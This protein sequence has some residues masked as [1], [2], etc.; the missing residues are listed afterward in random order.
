M[1]KFFVMIS[2]VISLFGC[3]EEK[4]NETRSVSWY[5][6]NSVARNEKLN[7]CKDNPGDLEKTANCINAKQAELQTASK[8]QNTRF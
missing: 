4:Q 5:K 8:G 3:F 7:E 1:F 6:E 2:V